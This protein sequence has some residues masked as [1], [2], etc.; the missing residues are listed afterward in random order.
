MYPNRSTGYP[1]SSFALYMHPQ[2]SRKRRSCERTTPPHRC[3]SPRLK[4][5][6]VACSV[7]AWE[8]VG[9][10]SDFDAGG[11]DALAEAAARA[12]QTRDARHSGSM[13]TESRVHGGNAYSQ[14][15]ICGAETS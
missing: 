1:R 4:E 7:E 13:A 6:R 5:D 12:R 11:K 2:R 15:P 9:S 10:P 14:T 3:C 8:R